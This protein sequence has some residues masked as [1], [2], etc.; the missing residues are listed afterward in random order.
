MESSSSGRG[1]D[2]GTMARWRA[3]PMT[4]CHMWQIRET[5][6]VDNSDHLLLFISVHNTGSGHC[7]KTAGGFSSKQNKYLEKSRN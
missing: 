6:F 7:V 3:R 4:W 5:A 1:S 2:G